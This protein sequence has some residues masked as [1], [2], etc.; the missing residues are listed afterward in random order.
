MFFL[1]RRLEKTCFLSTSVCSSRVVFRPLPSL[2]DVLLHGQALSKV[3]YVDTVFLCLFRTL[4]RFLRCKTFVLLFFC[5]VVQGDHFPLSSYSFFLYITSHQVCVL[6]YP[7]SPPK[8]W[9]DFLFP[10][11]NVS[12]RPRPLFLFL[13]PFVPHGRLSN[14]RT[15]SSNYVGAFCPDLHECRPI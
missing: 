9:Q 13:P 5:A 12:A 11:I 14:G 1:F 4:Y 10:P 3:M 7:F 2:I 6:R 15:A 8:L